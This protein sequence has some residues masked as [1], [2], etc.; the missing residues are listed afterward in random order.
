MAKG[1]SIKIKTK[2]IEIM[3]PTSSHLIKYIEGFNAYD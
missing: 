2:L 1:M 3:T